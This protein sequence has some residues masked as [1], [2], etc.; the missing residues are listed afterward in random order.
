MSINLSD[1]PD[2]LV[3]RLTRVLARRPNYGIAI[4]SRRWLESQEEKIQRLPRK[5]LEPSNV[6]QRLAIKIQD[7]IDPGRV[8]RAVP[9]AVLCG[10]HASLNAFMIRRLFIALA[11]EVTVYTDP[12]RSW[13]GRTSSPE[14]S[15]FV[16]RLDAITALWIEPRLFYK[17]YGLAPF[18]NRLIFVRS[19]CEACCLA[20]VGANGQVLSDLR[21]A[22]ID[23]MERRA[24]NPPSPEPRLYRF[25]EAWISHLRKRN[26]EV[27][28]PEECRARCEALLVEL[29]AA[30]PQIKAWRDEQTQIHAELRAAKQPVFAELRRTSSG[31]KIVPLSNRSRSQ[32][33]TRNGIPI[34][35]VDIEGADA[36]RRAALSSSTRESIYRPDSLAGYSEVRRPRH[37]AY[38]PHNEVRPDAPEPVRV[39]GTSPGSPTES[40]LH[41]FE[42]E[43]PLDDEAGF[44]DDNEGPRDVDG[45]DYAEG[46]RSRI[47]VQDWYSSRVVESDLWTAQ[48]EAKSMISMV[49][50]AFRPDSCDVAPSAVPIPLQVK[51]DRAQGTGNPD[52]CPRS[53]V[54]V[55]TDCTAYTVNHSSISPTTGHA[56]PMPRI[57][58]EYR[59]HR[60]SSESSLEA[61]PTMENEQKSHTCFPPYVDPF[62]NG[63]DP[64][65]TDSSSKKFKTVCT[66]WPAPPH[67]SSH[68]KRNKIDR[69]RFLPSDSDLDSKLSY[70]RQE[71]LKDRFKVKDLDTPTTHTVSAETRSAQSLGLSTVP[72]LSSY[73]R[74][75]TGPELKTPSDVHRA[76]KR[77]TPQPVALGN[78]TD[79]GAG[80]SLHDDATELGPDD[81]VSNVRWNRKSFSS[82]TQL[83]A[84]RDKM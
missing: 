54:S 77:T 69:K 50:P 46:E 65:E 62:M 63:T 70:R 68:S 57:P 15:A 60:R 81:S 16:G 71:F 14:L 12:L 83:G 59:I 80:E 1:M 42:Q 3:V 76:K 66:D 29:R 44:E 19:G 64:N 43:I 32:R 74:T 78:E 39:S 24:A 45:K 34:A 61:N 20:A 30:R 7:S 25:V 2:D 38:D 73:G 36:G 35:L 84:F 23:R 58:S 17:V 28:R 27:G 82:V 51:K 47:K 52:N 4:P 13:Q 5:L 72:S 79:R 18:D 67:G 6:F 8:P 9:P 48:D 40:F 11:Y 37:D 53:P 49:H 56:P 21:A 41:R 55:W 26:E 33:Q 10:T 75:T 31:D 22:L